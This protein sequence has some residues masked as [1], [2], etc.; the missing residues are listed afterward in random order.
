MVV[1]TSALLSIMFADEEKESFI[2]AVA[3]AAVRLMSAASFV[4]AGIVMEVRT[5][6]A[7]RH[8]LQLFV[9]RATI[10]IREAD[11]EQAEIALDAFRRYGKGLHAASLNYGDCFSYALSIA[12]GEPL[13]YKGNDLSLSRTFRRPAYRTGPHEANGNAHGL[14]RGMDGTRQ[15]QVSIRAGRC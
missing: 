8:Q 6:P 1:D 14:D 10:D 11:R 15:K 2:R 12:T 5:G 9:A 4:E 7:G 13:L 3:E